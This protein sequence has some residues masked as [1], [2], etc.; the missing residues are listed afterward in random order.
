MKFGNGDGQRTRI[1]DP[2]AKSVAGIGEHI[3]V[4]QPP[5]PVLLT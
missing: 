2:A 3:G 4:D 5:L 1:I